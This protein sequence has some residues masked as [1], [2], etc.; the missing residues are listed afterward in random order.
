[1]AIPVA[2]GI[3]GMTSKLDKATIAPGSPQ[4]VDC[5]NTVIQTSVRAAAETNH[6]ICWRSSLLAWRTRT[7]SEIT[8]PRPATN[9]IG[10]AMKSTNTCTTWDGLSLPVT[11][12]GPLSGPS[13]IMDDTTVRLMERAPSQATGRQRFEG[14]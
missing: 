1:M 14:G 3:E 9:S 13:S 6:L 4:R 7:N 11:S 10:T 2:M 12:A 5:P 8:A